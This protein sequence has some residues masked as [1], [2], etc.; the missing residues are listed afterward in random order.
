MSL[1]LYPLSFSGFLV[2]E[3]KCGPFLHGLG[4]LLAPAAYLEVCMKTTDLPFPAAFPPQV[5]EP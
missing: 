2:E 1:R 4:L 5:L 3:V